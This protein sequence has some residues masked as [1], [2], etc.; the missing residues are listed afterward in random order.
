MPAKPKDRNRPPEEMT[1]EELLEE[2]EYRRAE[3]A[4]LKKLDA[5]IQQKK[6][7]QQKK[8]K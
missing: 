1:R 4:Y 3:M 7:A 2:L 6:L 5:L 8:Q